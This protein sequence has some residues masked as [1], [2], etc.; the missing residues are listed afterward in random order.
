M[1]LP[2]GSPSF[3]A[4]LAPNCTTPDG[5]LIVSMPV[6]VMAVDAWTL[7]GAYKFDLKSLVTNGYQKWAQL[8]SDGMQDLSPD[9]TDPTEVPVLEFCLAL[10]IG[11]SPEN[12]AYG[13]WK[14]PARGQGGL[15][16]QVDGLKFDAL[17]LYTRLADRSVKT[18]R[19]NWTVNLG[20]GTQ[21]GASGVHI[22]WGRYV[23]PGK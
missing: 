8:S 9:F 17:A 6:A 12:I 15:V 16:V 13:S 5:G 20:T 14:S 23:V 21:S 22:E 2:V 11:A 4:Y 7:V 19:A 18:R 1:A 10:G 3:T